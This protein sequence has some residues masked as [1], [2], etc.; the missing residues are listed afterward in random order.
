MWDEIVGLEDVKDWLLNQ[1]AAPLEYTRAMNHLDVCNGV[2]LYGPPGTG[3]SMLA[4]SLASK[5]NIPFIEVL[6]SQLL[7]KW[8]GESETNI[9]QFFEMA[10]ELAPCIVFIGKCFIV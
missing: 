6:G 9:R 7:S 8:H 2:L 5:I 1:L 10:A 3:K 4:R